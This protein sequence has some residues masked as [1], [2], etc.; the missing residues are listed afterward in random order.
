MKDFIILSKPINKISMK[1]YYIIR[2]EYQDIIFKTYAAAFNEA[3]LLDHKS[4]RNNLGEK[5]Y[6]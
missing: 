6:I 5:Y 2:T 3:K 4:F 1:I